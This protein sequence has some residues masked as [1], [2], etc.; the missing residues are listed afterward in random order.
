M[1]INIRGIENIEK[2]VPTLEKKIEYL[3]DGSYNQIDEWILNT[4]GVNLMDTLINDMVDDTRTITN[5][6]H[7]MYEIFGIEAAR[8]LLIQELNS[9]L[10]SQ[11]VAIRHMTMLIDL[12]TCKGAIMPIERHGINRSVDTGPL[13]KATFEESTEI[14]VK[15]STFAEID[16][17]SGVSSNIMMAQCPKIGTNSFDVLFDETKFIKNL[18]D[19]NIKNKN[20]KEA[21]DEFKEININDIEEEINDKF[22]ENAFDMINNKFDFGIDITKEEETHIQIHNFSDEGFDVKKMNTEE[23]KKTTIKISKK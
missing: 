7:E 13:A 10:L 19:I 9:Q 1:E 18:T 11:D 23:N 3:D 8:E 2:V 16:N 15:A 12:M 21:K 4:D 20:K 14:L 22:K 5:D 17:M 6:I